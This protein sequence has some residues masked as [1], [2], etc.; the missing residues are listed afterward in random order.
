MS[1]RELID[2]IGAAR[3][4]TALE[5]SPDTVRSWRMGKRHPGTRTM[6]KALCRLAEGVKYSDVA[7]LSGSV[8]R[9]AD[10]AAVERK[11]K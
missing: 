5:V 6:R 9:P 2:R 10:R 3:V 7:W 4:A 11:T 1:I 8:P